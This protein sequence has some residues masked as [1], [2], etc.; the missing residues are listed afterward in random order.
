MS[1]SSCFFLVFR[2]PC[3]SCPSF[4][5]FS[6]FSSFFSF[7]YFSSCSS[8]FF[9]IIYDVLG[10]ISVL[11]FVCNIRLC[12]VIAVWW[13]G[14]KGN[15]GIIWEG[16]VGVFYYTSFIKYLPGVVYKY[17]GSFTKLKLKER[18]RTQVWFKWH[19]LNRTESKGG[20]HFK[21]GTRVLIKANV[22]KT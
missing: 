9:Q 2:V 18:K 8:C 4:S 13:R 3:S 17:C 1:C 22:E 12:W 10:L 11:F 20:F 19:P 15:R 21:K 16:G 5:S 14:G 6:S 7:F